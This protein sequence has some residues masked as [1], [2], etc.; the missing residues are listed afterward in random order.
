M[1]SSGYLHTQ[2]KKMEADISINV[3]LVMPRELLR[4]I[5]SA[6][7]RETNQDNRSA[8]IRELIEYGL[9]EKNHE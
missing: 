6:R 5:E 1:L 4:R 7:L 9:K 3:T 2:R 8:F